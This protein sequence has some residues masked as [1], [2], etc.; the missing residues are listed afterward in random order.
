VVLQLIKAVPLVIFLVLCIKS[1][2]DARK[3]RLA[4]K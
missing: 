4:S 2:I 3:A 1:F